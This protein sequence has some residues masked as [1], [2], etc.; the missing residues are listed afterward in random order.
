MQ[1][2]KVGVKELQIQTPVASVLKDCQTNGANQWRH[3]HGARGARAPPQ[4]FQKTKNYFCIKAFCTRNFF[5]LGYPPPP[6]HEPV[7]S[8]E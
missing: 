5:G 7:R 3:A 2:T 6:V 1:I 4:Y 8:V